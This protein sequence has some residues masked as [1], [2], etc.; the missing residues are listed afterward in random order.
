MAGEKVE[1]GD[2]FAVS[3]EEKVVLK[4]NGPAEFLLFDLP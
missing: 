1:S 2:G 4:S 3:D